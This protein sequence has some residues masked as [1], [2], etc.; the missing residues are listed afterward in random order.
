MREY[1]S[2][3]HQMYPICLDNSRITP[4]GCIRDLTCTP[5]KWWYESLCNWDNSVQESWQYQKIRARPNVSRKAPL[6]N[7][8]KMKS[9]H[10]PGVYLVT[11]DDHANQW[12]STNLNWRGNIPQYGI[13]CVIGR[14]IEWPRSIHHKMR[15]P[16]HPNPQLNQIHGSK[17]VY[18]KKKY[19][20]I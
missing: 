9:N 17:F 15:D 6:E 8:G 7:Q 1:A 18:W 4:W 5:L 10:Q 3:W 19:D 11:G 20:D 16:S 12:R 14:K 13:E 2:V